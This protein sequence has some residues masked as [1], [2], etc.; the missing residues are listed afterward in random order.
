LKVKR[1]T[2]HVTP[3]LME[4]SWR[5]DWALHTIFKRKRQLTKA[6]AKASSSKNEHSNKKIKEEL[7]TDFLD[8]HQYI[9]EISS[10]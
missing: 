4:I 5:I 1:P 9:K 8:V 7:T 6:M 2:I 10:L 3:L